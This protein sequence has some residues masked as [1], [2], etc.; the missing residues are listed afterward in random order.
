MQV[1]WVVLPEIEQ[2]PVVHVL[3]VL[4]LDPDIEQ[5]PALVQLFWLV[6]PDSEQ[7]PSDVQLFWLL[8][9]EIEQEECEMQLLRF[10]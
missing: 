1:F 10:E 3:W 4:W 5:V 8:S 9:P 2:V 7:V 6:L